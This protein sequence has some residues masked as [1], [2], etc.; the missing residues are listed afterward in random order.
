ML[1]SIFATK[2]D[3]TQA[4]SKQGKRYPVTRCQVGDNLIVAKQELT[5]NPYRVQ[6]DQDF[7]GVIYEVGYGRKK[8][9]NMTQP[10]RTKLEKSGFKQ[11]V[12]KFYGVRFEPNND[13]EADQPKVGQIV[14]FSEIFKVGDVVKVQ[15]QT[16]GHGFAGVV[17]RYGFKGGQRTHGQRDRERA[18]GSIGASAD[19]GRVLPGKKMPGRMGTTTRTI[20][21]LVVLYLDPEKKEVWLS[22]PIP[23]SYNSTVK[24]IKT[25]QHKDI[26]LDFKASGIK[27]QPAEKN[28]ETEE[29]EKEKKAKKE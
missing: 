11:G 21:N 14:D 28:E 23:G 20:Q 4:W 6:K 16:K 18:P 1:N 29:T 2:R 13:E 17:K 3:M 8:I 9:K 26:E 27:E 22:G 7:M 5:P 24:I 25:G 15:G 19:P 10:L 12:K